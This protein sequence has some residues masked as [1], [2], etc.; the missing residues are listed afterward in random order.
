M[1][2]TKRTANRYWIDV[3]SASLVKEINCRKTLEP[4]AKTATFEGCCAVG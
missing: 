1:N 3:V 4:K 2:K